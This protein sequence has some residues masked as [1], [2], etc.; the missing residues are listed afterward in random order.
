[1]RIL[2]RVA[3]RLESKAGKRAHRVE[4]VDGEICLEWWCGSRKL[5]LYIEGPETV[6]FIKSWGPDMVTEMQDGHLSNLNNIKVLMRWLNGEP[7]C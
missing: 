4:T 6:S 7:P 5:T 3:N 1:M 2:R